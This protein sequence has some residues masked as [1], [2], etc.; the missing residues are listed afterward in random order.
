VKLLE[1]VTRLCGTVID[2][3]VEQDGVTEVGA[4]IVDEA[5]LVTEHDHIVR[6]TSIEV[7]REEG[8]AVYLTMAVLGS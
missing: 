6:D 3:K 1:S 7:V 8:G 2:S 5:L 4:S